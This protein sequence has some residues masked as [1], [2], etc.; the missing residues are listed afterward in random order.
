MGAEDR[1]L[2]SNIY[3]FGDSEGVGYTVTVGIGVGRGGCGTSASLGSPAGA[4]N[5][6]ET[7]PNVEKLVKNRTSAV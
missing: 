2:R 7:T 3:G 1:D 5:T 4:A 6:T